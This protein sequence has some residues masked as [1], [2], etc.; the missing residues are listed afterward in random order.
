MVC[1]RK[2]SNFVKIVCSHTYTHV[3]RYNKMKKF[4]NSPK[5]I[6]IVLD[7]DGLLM[8]GTATGE[9]TDPIDNPEGNPDLGAGAR[10]FSDDIE[11]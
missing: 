3:G 7:F 10:T 1:N 11:W 4:Y 6:Q 9:G 5:S 2:T 8:D